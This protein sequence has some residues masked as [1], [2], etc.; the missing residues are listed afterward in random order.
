MQIMAKKGI[1][2]AKEEV[3]RTK[4]LISEKVDLLDEG[5]QKALEEMREVKKQFEKV[6]ND[7]ANP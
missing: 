2:R 3:V 4:D 5:K 6:S 1:T 7:K